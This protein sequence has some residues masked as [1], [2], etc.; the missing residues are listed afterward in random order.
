M[1]KLT[2]DPTNAGLQTHTVPGSTFGFT[3]A[4]IGDLGATEYTLATI[5][6]DV[7]GSTEGFT[8]DLRR[9]LEVAIEACQR[10]PRREHLL[11][12]VVLFSTR[13][14]GHTQ[15]LHGFKPLADINPSDY[16]RLVAG[17]ATPLWDATYDAVGA[18]AEYGRQL[19]EADYGTNAIVF[20][21]TDG[22]EGN[23]WGEPVSVMR[24]ANIAR[25]LQEIVANEWLES[26]VTVLIGINAADCR[27]A[28]ERFRQDVGFTQYT[29]VVDATSASLAKLA[30]FV[31]QSIVSQSQA[32]GTGGPSQAISA[33]I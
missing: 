11:A 5:V 7:T 22:Q 20:V 24:P 3:A 25:Q 6:V 21:I 32:L 10:S 19:T 1:P 33:T 23:G 18:V 17:G 9:M 2:P 8:N 13:F 29:D 27:D 16:P 12:R 30:A 14:S 26:V 15:E 4:R 31:S 28:L